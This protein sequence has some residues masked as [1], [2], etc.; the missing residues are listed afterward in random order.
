MYLWLD[1]DQHQCSNYQ[2]KRHQS[3]AGIKTPL[4]LKI[5]ILLL[6]LIEV[7]ESNSKVC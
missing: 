1:L 6:V 4:D 3:K 5:Q 2:E 7:S